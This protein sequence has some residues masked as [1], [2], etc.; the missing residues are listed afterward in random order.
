MNLMSPSR[1][2]DDFGSQ[3]KGWRCDDVVFEL[4]AGQPIVMPKHAHDAYQIG[5]TTRDPG[6]YLCDGRVWIAPPGSV[7]VFH[8]GQVHSA[9]KIGI[10][11]R[12]AVSKIMFVR[13]E[14]MHAIAST[15]DCRP[16]ALPR[17]NNVVI[18]DEAFIEEF[19]RVHDLALTNATT[20][21]KETGLH[22][23]LTRLILNFGSNQD[24]LAEAKRRKAKARLVR[25]FV[26]SNYIDNIS[27]G[28]LAEVAHISQYHLNRVFAN[29]VGMPPHAFQTQMRVQRAKHLLLNGMPV[30]EVALQTGFFDQ[31]HFTRHFRRIVGVAP[32][33]YVSHP[34]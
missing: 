34:A 29:E 9:S 7:M 20:L 4:H 28:Q 2:I 5:T 21:E 26:E 12:S 1:R 19:C 3:V 17:F 31:S 30:V 6:E 13:P 33:H 22:A 27:L 32:S 23:M 8:P 18:R 10:R 14:R 24:A 25:D 11:S 16:P 15:L